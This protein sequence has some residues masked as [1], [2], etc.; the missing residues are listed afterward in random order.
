MA[1][2]SIEVI[3]LSSNSIKEQLEHERSVLYELVSSYGIGHP[4]VIKQSE[5]LDELINKHSKTQIPTYTKS[6][7]E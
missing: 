5:L 4:L 6:E 3:D 7:D 2:I 1:R